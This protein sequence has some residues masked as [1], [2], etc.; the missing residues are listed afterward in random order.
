MPDA[1]ESSPG[2]GELR[3][4]LA[5]LRDV[6]EAKDAEIAVLRRGLDAVREQSRLL[7][8]KVAELAPAS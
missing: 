1:P 8:L 3:A 7:A 6:V 2:A 4:L 5:R